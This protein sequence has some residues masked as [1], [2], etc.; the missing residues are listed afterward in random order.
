MASYHNRREFISNNRIY[1][2]SRVTKF[3][4]VFDLAISEVPECDIRWLISNNKLI[5]IGLQPAAACCH[6]LGS[7][8]TER[9]CS[10]W[11]VIFVN[12]LSLWSVGRIDNAL[13]VPDL[14]L[15]IRFDRQQFVEIWMIL[16][17]P[18]RLLNLIFPY[19]N[20][21]VVSTRLRIF[22]FRLEIRDIPYS[23]RA[24]NSS[25]K[26]ESWWVLRTSI[27]CIWL[28]FRSGDAQN[29]CGMASESH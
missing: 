18:N 3:N 5:G 14:Y 28:Q 9:E 21:V 29:W 10:Q 4:G 13:A 19:A 25:W 20:A 11:L 1:C 16:E 8:I 2:W 6:F 22:L 27:L 26:N 12:I 24:F 17:W 23:N 15:V 7:F